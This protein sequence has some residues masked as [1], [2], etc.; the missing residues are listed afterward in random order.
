MS[1]TTS[2]KAYSMPQIVLHWAIAILI[3]ANYI[4]SEGMGHQL[5]EHLENAGFQTNWVGTFH[6]Y[7]GLTVLGLVLVR[8][9]VRRASPVPETI[10][11][12]HPLLDKVQKLAHGLLYVLMLLVPVFGAMAWYLGMEFM[13]DVHVVAMNTMM[14]IALLHALAALYHHH[15]LKDRVLMRML[16]RE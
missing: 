9:I 7:V 8:L 10:S 5:D 6:V 4:V 2:T 12:G 3:V 14:I 1:T 16:G 13:G 15:V 11:A